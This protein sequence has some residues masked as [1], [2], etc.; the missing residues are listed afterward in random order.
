MTC[1]V[2]QQDGDPGKTIV[3]SSSV[4][5]RAPAQGH[6]AVGVPFTWEGQTLFLFHSDLQ[7]IE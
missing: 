1:R 6:Q 2:S 3:L 7:L 5:A 4:K